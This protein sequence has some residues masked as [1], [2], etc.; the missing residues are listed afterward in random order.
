MRPVESSYYMEWSMDRVEKIVEHNR[1]GLP[2]TKCYSFQTRS[3][4][5]GGY[6]TKNEC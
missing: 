2:N 5:E 1:D 6:L 3:D 4:N